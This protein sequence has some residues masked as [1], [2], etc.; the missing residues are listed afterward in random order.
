[1][2]QTLLPITMVHLPLAH[3]ASLMQI[4]PSFSLHAPLPLQTMVPLQSGALSVMPAGMFE[5][6][7]LAAP[8]QV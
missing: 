2:T 1:M 4:S 6:V 3:S 5:Q 7:P 8:M